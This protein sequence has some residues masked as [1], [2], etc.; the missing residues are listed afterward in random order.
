MSNDLVLFEQQMK[1]VTPQFADV[2]G[3]RMPPERL[4]RTVLMACEKVPKLLQCNRQSLMNAG[5]TFGVLALEVDGVTGQGY[6]L[7]FANVAQPVI[8]YKGY[9]T[10]AGRGGI[11]I[12][13]AVVR[14]GDEFDWSKGTK[15]FVRHKAKLDNRGRIIA[16]WSHAEANGR[17]PIVEVMGIGD[18]EDVRARSPGAKKADSPWNDPKIGLPAMYEKTVKRRLARSTPMNWASPEF[19]YAAVMEE[20]FEERGK[21]SY[22]APG[23]GVIIDGEDAGP[24]AKREGDGGTPRLEDLSGKKDDQELEAW[25]IEGREAAEHGTAILSS[26]WSRMSPRARAALQ[27]MKDEELKPMAAKADAEIASQ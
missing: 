26:W 25:K 17:P 15:A 1:A 20:A 7:P 5:M 6:I 23:R 18:L 10:I 3:N 19:Q 9:N 13:G 4:I 2:L 22:I 11:T 14:E 12:T 21:H 16:A 27:K 8:G 24:I